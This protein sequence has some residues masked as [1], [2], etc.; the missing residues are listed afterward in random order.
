MLTS[1]KLPKT[2]EILHSRNEQL[3]KQVQHFSLLYSTE[4]IISDDALNIM[5]SLPMMDDLDCEPTTEELS[6][7]IGMMVP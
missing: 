4:N 2:G 6:K 5:D 7:A 1:P 3:D